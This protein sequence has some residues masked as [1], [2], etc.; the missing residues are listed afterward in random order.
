[1]ARYSAWSSEW[2]SWWSSSWCVEWWSLRTIHSWSCSDCCLSWCW[3]GMCTAS[4]LLSSWGCLAASYTWRRRRELCHRCQT[5]LYHPVYRS[6]AGT[7]WYCHLRQGAWSYLH[8]FWSH[9]WSLDRASMRWIKA[10]QKGPCGW[11]PQT[12]HLKL[13]WKVCQLPTKS[14]KGWLFSTS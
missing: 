4:P 1:M 2:A 14:T 8:G 5:L 6:H 11:S 3:P 10:I 13:W 7:L 12:S 9:S